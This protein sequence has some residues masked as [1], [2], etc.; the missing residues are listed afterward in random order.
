MEFSEK[1]IFP[2]HNQVGPLKQTRHFQKWRCLVYSMSGA[3]NLHNTYHDIQLYRNQ[4]IYA[5][6]HFE[7]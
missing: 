2:T 4:G 3:T 6:Q 5:I 1:E 7:I